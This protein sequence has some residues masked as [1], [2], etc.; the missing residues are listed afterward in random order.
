MVAKYEITRLHTKGLL[1]GLTT[2][3]VQNHDEK[4]PPKE[5]TVV[6]CAIGGGSYKIIKVVK[7]S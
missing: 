1:A 7:L 5:G 3:N 6:K 2:V 4:Y